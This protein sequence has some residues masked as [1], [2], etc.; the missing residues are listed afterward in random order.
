[1]SHTKRNP[2]NPPKTQRVPHEILHLVLR[3][4]TWPLI[5][6]EN[7]SPAQPGMPSTEE[8]LLS[9]LCRDLAQSQNHLGWKRYLRSSSPV[10]NLMLLLY[11]IAVLS[12]SSTQMKSDTSSLP[13]QLNYFHSQSHSNICSVLFGQVTC[14]VFLSLVTGKPGTSDGD[15][16]HG[17]PLLDF[18]SS[19]LLSSPIFLACR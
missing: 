12:P 19:E 1:M 2:T 13:K 17:K 8:K 3:A 15:A 7:Q 16:L 14:W 9:F 10:I 6:Q 11:S 18:G 4:L 5:M